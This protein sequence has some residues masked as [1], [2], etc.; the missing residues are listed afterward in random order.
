MSGL[1]VFPK[2]VETTATVSEA[3]LPRESFAP[4]NLHLQ[5]LTGDLRAR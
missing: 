5:A 3:F 1:Q 2:I 4:T